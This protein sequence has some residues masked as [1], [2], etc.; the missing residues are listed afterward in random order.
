[1]PENDPA[2]LQ[3]IVGSKNPVKV[4]CV[5]E[6]FSQAFGKIGLVE[7]VDAQSDIP[8]QPRSEEETLHP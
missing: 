5:R 6:A 8:A 3:V 2:L 4:G 7:G 1:V